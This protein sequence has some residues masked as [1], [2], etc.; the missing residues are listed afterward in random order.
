MI[1]HG[2]GWFSE[3]YELTGEASNYA[4]SID[5]PH[6]IDDEQAKWVER[7]KAK[8]G[9]DPGIGASGLTYDYMRMA[10]KVLNKAGT[11]DFDTLVETSTTTPTEACGTTTSSRAS[12]DRT[13]FRRA[14]S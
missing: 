6:V 3:W 14:R 11:L 5:S 2:L 10:F 9:I 13:R 4:V 8:F 7:Y 12:Q 1:A